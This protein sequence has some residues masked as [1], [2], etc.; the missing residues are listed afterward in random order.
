MIMSN[1][2]LAARMDAIRILSD[3]DCNLSSLTITYDE[4]C[5]MW[6]VEYEHLSDEDWER[7]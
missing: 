7:A 6:C 2:Y 3:F 1:S 5:Q 4:E